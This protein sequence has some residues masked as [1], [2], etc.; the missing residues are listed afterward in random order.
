MVDLRVRANP[1]FRV[2]A[3][4]RPLLLVG[5][6]TGLAGLRALLKARI[7]AGHQRN[8]LLFGERSAAHDGFHAGELQAWRDDGSLQRLELVYSRAQPQRRYVQEALVEAAPEVR[9]WVAEGAAIYVRGSLREL[10]RA[11]CRARGW[12]CG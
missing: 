12:Q 1:G 5:N 4:D 2:P 11:S 8:W 3:D 9:P 10:G 6:G 7:N